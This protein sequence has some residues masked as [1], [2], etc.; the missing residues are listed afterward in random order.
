MAAWPKGRPSF[1]AADKIRASMG[2]VRA[3]DGARAMRLFAPM[4]VEA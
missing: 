3:N 4:P 2:G 1:K